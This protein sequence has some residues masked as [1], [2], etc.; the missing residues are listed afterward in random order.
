ML[1]V[2]ISIRARCTTLCDKVCQFL[3]TGRWFYP[4]PPFSSTNKIDCHDIT[5]ILLK[6]AL[7]TIKQTQIIDTIPLWY[8]Y[9]SFNEDTMEKLIFSEVGKSMKMAL[10]ALT[11]SFGWVSIIVT[12]YHSD[13]DNIDQTYQHIFVL[14]IKINILFLPDRYYWY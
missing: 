8:L 12:I 13:G 6:V 9:R 7:S 5:E 10:V 3:A 11:K 4:G 14:V 2:R 1:W